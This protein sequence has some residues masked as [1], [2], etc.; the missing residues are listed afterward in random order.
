[1]GADFPEQEVSVKK[2]R[3]LDKV[4]RGWLGHHLRNS[5]CVI[6]TLNELGETEE[7]KKVIDHMEADLRM[8]GL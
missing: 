6:G 8:F 4:H 3:E 2:I 1:M 5:L 7:V